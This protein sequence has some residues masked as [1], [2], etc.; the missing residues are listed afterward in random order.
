MWIRGAGPGDEADFDDF[1][2]SMD[3]SLDKPPQVFQPPPRIIQPV[4]L[5]RIGR[6][7][8][9][10]TVPPPAEPPPRAA[11]PP[12][13]LGTAPP[14]FG[15]PPPE[16]PTATPAPPGTVPPKVVDIDDDV[17]VSREAPQSQ[18]GFRLDPSDRAP[19]AAEPSVEIAAPTPTPAPAEPS[20]VV[21]L[22]NIGEDRPAAAEVPVEEPAQAAFAPLSSTPSMPRPSKAAMREASTVLVRAQE[23]VPEPGDIRPVRP[24]SLFRLG[25]LLVLLAVGGLLA[26]VSAANDWRP[27][28]EEPELSLRVAFGLAERKAPPRPRI[29]D[30]VEAEPMRGNLEVRDL[31]VSMVKVGRNS[32]AAVL[33]GT[34]VNGSN[35]RHARIELEATLSRA[36]GAM[37]LKTRR[38]SCCEALSPEQAEAVA[39]DPKHQHYRRAPGN[40]HVDPEQSQP[41]TVVFRDVDLGEA[42]AAVAVKYSEQER[43]PK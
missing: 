6:A 36:P 26:F 34:L 32:R 37:P 39:R 23:D 13:G 21:D 1:E 27:V 25:L 18:V 42:H 8:G 43:P 16:P 11:T 24:P 40:S 31:K 20:I 41:F 19:L 30:M 12:V 29:P 7:L 15:P 9:V 35:R 2:M 38:L 14:E 33:Q 5:G 3:G 22:D 10:S 17:V 4:P 28:W